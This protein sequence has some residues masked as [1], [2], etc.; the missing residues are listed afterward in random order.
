MVDYGI[1]MSETLAFGD[2]YNDIHLL[3]EVGYG[4]AVANAREEVKAVAQEVTSSNLADGVASPLEQQILFIC[5]TN[6]TGKKILERPHSSK[7][8]QSTRDI[9]T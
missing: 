7:C 3:A 6:R 5:C 9:F 1:P 2:N 4:V 8:F